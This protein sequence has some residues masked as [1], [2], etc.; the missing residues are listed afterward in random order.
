MR[1]DVP[2]IPQD[3]PWTGLSEALVRC[4]NAVLVDGQGRLAGILTQGDVL[5]ALEPNTKAP[6]NVLDAATKEVIVTYTDELVSEAVFKMLDNDVGRLP[7]V[8]PE[9]TTRLVGYLDRSCVMAARLRWYHDERVREPG[10]LHQA[11]RRRGR[12]SAAKR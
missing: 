5:R 6:R 4:Q 10:W 9:D 12:V 7:V 3:R 11:V 2:T 1:K 8:A